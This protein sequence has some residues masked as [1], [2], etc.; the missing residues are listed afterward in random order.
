VLEATIDTVNAVASLEV[1]DA[2]DPLFT[3]RRCGQLALGGQRLGFLGEVSEEGR[4]RFDLRGP[5]TVAEI[6]LATLVRHADLVPRHEPSS[7]FPAVERDLNF[8]VAESVRWAD[9]AATVSAS[10]GELLEDLRHLETYRD[11]KRLG[12]D[13]KSLV[14]RL[15]VR[16]P[17]GTLTGEEADAV[18]DKIVDACQKTH[19]ATLRA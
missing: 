16:K 7:P 4:K 10:A 9:L 6:D 5:T 18:R 17:D 2:E 15:V 12:S 11:A 14:L 13:K 8:E 1:V 3:L 19:G